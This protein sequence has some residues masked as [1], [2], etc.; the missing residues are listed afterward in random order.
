MA[1]LAP[2]EWTVWGRATEEYVK[3]FRPANP[4]LD[5]SWA[6]NG[7]ILVDDNALVEP[8]WVCVRG[9]PATSTTRA[10]RRFLASRRSTRIKVRSRDEG[11]YRPFQTARGL[12]IETKFKEVHLPERRITREA[13]LLA[14]GAGAKDITVRDIQRFRGIATG[15]TVVVKGLKKNELK[16]ADRFLGLEADGGAKARPKS[17]FQAEDEDQAWRDLW[18]L[19]E[20]RRWLCARPE[21]WPSKFCAGT[22][23]FASHSLCQG[24]S[25]RGQFLC[26]QTRPR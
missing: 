2:S 1:F 21:T 20:E 16:A 18:E 12:D 25:R 6:F 24:R 11:P 5:L 8:W 10:S 22:R 3:A 15:W 13:A 23:E 4:R 14:E 19:F 9:W 17:C 26:L 7:K